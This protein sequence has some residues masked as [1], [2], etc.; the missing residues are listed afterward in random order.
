MLNSIIQEKYLGF[1]KDKRL[2]NSLYETWQKEELEREKRM[3]QIL[4]EERIR[5]IKQQE[6]EEFLNS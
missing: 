6:L 3:K 4:E 2:S 1:L 5:I